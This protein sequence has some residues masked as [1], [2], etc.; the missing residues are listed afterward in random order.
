MHRGLVIGEFFY[1]FGFFESARLSS[2]GFMLGQFD[3]VFFLSIWG[4]LLT[5][6]CVIE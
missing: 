3:G 1:M 5:I 2:H 4:R 6:S